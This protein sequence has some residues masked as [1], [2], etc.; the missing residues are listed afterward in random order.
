M[1]VGGEAA[2]VRVIDGDT[3]EISAETI[4]LW[5][6]DAPEDGQTCRR[7]ETSYDCG[8]E[9]LAALSRLVSGRAVR[10][11]ARYKDRYGRTVARC[12]I[13]GVDLG[14]ELVRLG[15]ALDYERYSKGHYRQN[16]VEAKAKGRGLWSGEFAPPW[17]WRHPS[18]KQ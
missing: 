18:S 12:F 16:Q 3:L 15:W 11:E 4:R 14:G 6:I 7:A 17:E 1:A 9:A 8:A 13:G 5:G 10:C 2:G